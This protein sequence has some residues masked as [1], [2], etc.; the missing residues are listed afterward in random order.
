MKLLLNEM[1]SHEIAAQVRRRGHDVIAATEPEHA[2]RYRQVEDD[3]VF[4]RVQEDER[5]IVTDN[6]KDYETARLAYERRG[7]PHH[8][9]IYALSPPFDR[10]QPEAVIGL[11]VRALDHFLRSLPP[12]HEPLN[13]AHLLVRAPAD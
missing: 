12:G 2:A 8:G 1:W 5:A 7:E 13:M 6:I 10:H 3:V 9:V 11:I 4:A